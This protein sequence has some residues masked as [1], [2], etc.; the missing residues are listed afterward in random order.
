MESI[1]AL[2]TIGAGGTSGN[3]GA[4]SLLNETSGAP[5]GFITAAFS[6]QAPIGWTNVASP[7]R[8]GASWISPI[9]TLLALLFVR[10]KVKKLKFHYRPQ[11]STNV[12]DQLV[13]AWTADPYHPLIGLGL[14]SL[15]ADSISS[16]RLLAMADT[17]PFSPWLAWSMDV[18]DSLDGDFEHYCSITGG[19][20]TVTTFDPSLR[21]AFAGTFACTNTVNTATVPYGVLY[22]ETEIEF[23]EFCPL[24]TQISGSGPDLATVLTVLPKGDGSIPKPI[25]AEKKT[26][27]EAQPVISAIPIEAYC[28]ETVHAH[29][30]ED[31]GNLHEES[32]G[33]SPCS[34]RRFCRI[35]RDDEPTDFVYVSRSKPSLFNVTRGR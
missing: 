34:D 26:V 9:M 1:F 29:V 28:H 18:T 30:V 25:E 24:I 21:L 14:T 22:A 3:N 13:F 6:P 16:Q 32:E 27:S 7:L 12:S 5:Q 11:V 17:M 23:R 4:L 15:E 33:E 20:P 10:F 31:E 19:T 35:H 2:G 8:T